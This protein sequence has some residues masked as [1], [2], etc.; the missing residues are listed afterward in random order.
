MKTTNFAWIATW[1]ITDRCNLRCA[2]CDHSTL[3][4]A[5]EADEGT[6]FAAV[7][8]RIGEYRP[9]ILN[10]TG[11]EPTLVSELPQLL[12]QAK[13]EWNPF[14]RVVHNGTQPSATVP[15]FAHLDRLVVSMDGPGA[16]NR[17]NRGIDGD[18]VLSKLGA[19]MPEARA[20]GVEVSINC[21]VT[22]QNVG[23][24]TELAEQV[25]AVSPD[26]IL[27]FSPVMPP[28]SDLS[29]LADPA[30]HAAFQA[31]YAALRAQGHNVIQTFDHILRHSSYDRIQ[32]Y[33]QYF[34]LRVT[35]EGKIGSC[36]MNVPVKLGEYRHSW[37][38]LLSAAGLRKA[39]D[40]FGKLVRANTGAAPDFTCTAICNCESW[41]D[42]LFLGLESDSLPV[43]LRG[44][45]GRVTP[46]ELDDVEGFVRRHI[47]P[48]FSAD[49]LRRSLTK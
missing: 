10:I 13:Q 38:R 12:A 37:R 25:T 30:V 33:N 40:M 6:V 5:A 41:L 7:L 8:R 29:I 48:A 35:P 49:S 4:R 45:S 26:I 21:V 34:S 23:A 28:L 15:L 31:R 36:A 39:R 46:A 24:I 27:C 20:H 47:N 18:A 1:R 19:I 44:L 2:Y 16:T 17:A 42:M 43:Y 11:G 22:R 32:C 9:K 3:R 14:V